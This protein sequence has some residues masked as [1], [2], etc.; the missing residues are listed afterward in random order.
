MPSTP[1]PLAHPTVGRATPSA[2]AACGLA[3]AHPHLAELPRI[4]TS[5][6]GHTA[7]P[8]H[9][10]PAPAPVHIAGAAHP[11]RQGLSCTGGV[12][13]WLYVADNVSS[14]EKEKKNLFG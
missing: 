3:A 10:L 2:R 1:H 7:A 14:R 12:K 9:H 13:Q 11:K 8:L 5:Y 6:P 4:R